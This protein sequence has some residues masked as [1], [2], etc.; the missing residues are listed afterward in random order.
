MV[1]RFLR[2]RTAQATIDAVKL[3]LRK[4]PHTLTPKEVVG[5]AA[6]VWYMRSN[7]LKHLYSGFTSV[8]DYSIMKAEYVRT[9]VFPVCP[10]RLRTIKQSTITRYAGL[11]DGGAY[12]Y[13]A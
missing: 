5:L 13:T 2:K 3:A 11:V 10:T 12:D 1:L 4:V 9:G 8:A 7:R 6:Y